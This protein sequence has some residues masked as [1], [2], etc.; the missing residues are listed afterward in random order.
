MFKR[1]LST[2]LAP[3]F[4]AQGMSTTIPLALGGA[5]VPWS[6]GAK[7]ARAFVPKLSDDLHKGSCGRIAVFGG[8]VEYTGAPYYGAMSAL[9]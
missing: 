7:H 4:T 6:L 5:A 3:A 2:L 8:S 1:A 9:K